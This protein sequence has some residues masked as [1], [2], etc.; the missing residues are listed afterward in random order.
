MNFG[1]S[2]E[3]IYSQCPA[4][5]EQ[6]KKREKNASPKQ[7]AAKSAAVSDDLSKIVAAWPSLPTAIRRAILALVDA[8]S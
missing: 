6:A 4:E 7:S 5:L 3:A 8:A 2:P 1:S